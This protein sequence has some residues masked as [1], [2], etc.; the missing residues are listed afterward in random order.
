MGVSMNPPR[1]D[2]PSSPNP[3]AGHCFYTTSAKSGHSSSAA[4]P[5][6]ADDPSEREYQGLALVPMSNGIATPRE[7]QKS[8]K[9]ACA[10]LARMKLVAP[11]PASQRKYVH[12]ISFMRE[13]MQAWPNI[14]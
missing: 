11:D 7:A 14:R 3:N 1:S 12:T 10:A 5:F 4:I 6:H 2:T 13:A 8:L 9:G